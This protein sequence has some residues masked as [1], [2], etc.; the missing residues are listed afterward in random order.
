M[1]RKPPAGSSAGKKPKGAKGD[2]DF[3]QRL[4]NACKAIPRG[5]VSTYGELAIVLGSCAR[6]VGQV[7]SQRG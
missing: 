3:T 2:S 4:Y 1:V 6:A 5:R 7:G